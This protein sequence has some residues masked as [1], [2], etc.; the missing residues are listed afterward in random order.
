MAF[1]GLVLVR[2]IQ[3]MEMTSLRD[4]SSNKVVAYLIVNFSKVEKYQK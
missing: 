1:W 2:N 4:A 3:I